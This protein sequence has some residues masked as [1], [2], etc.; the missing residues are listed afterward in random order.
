MPGS[1]RAQAH[2]RDFVWLPNPVVYT[3]AHNVVFS[4]DSPVEPGAAKPRSGRVLFNLRGLSNALI[5]IGTII[6]T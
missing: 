4:A 2:R 6:R 3:G 5:A 1:V